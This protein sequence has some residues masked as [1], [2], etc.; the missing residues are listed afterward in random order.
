MSHVIS[1]FTSVVTSQVIDL[2]VPQQLIFR[3]LIQVL[4]D[5]GLTPR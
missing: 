1:R 4:A 2:I 5:L 3:M